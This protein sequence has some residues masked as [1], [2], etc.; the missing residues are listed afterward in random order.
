MPM[1]AYYADREVLVTVNGSRPV[2][3]VTW[4]ITVQVERAPVS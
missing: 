4:S 3:E 1:L 2:N